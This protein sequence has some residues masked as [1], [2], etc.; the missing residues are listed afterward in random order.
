[1]GKYAWTKS[2][3]DCIWRGGPCNSIAECIDEA[4][5]EGYENGDTIAVGIVEPYEVRYVDVD[6]I[7]EGLQMQA[8]DDVGEVAEDWLECI[9]R[10]QRENLGDKLLRIVREWLKEI[11]EEPSFYKVLPLSDV[12]T[13][14]K[15]R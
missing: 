14:R 9:T 13:I 3:N 2:I 12:I 11:D 6:C 4:I 15:E 5:N 1:M 10:E 7:I 8:E